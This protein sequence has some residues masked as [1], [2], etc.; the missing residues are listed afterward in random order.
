MTSS[1]RRNGSQVTVK[2][3]L[4]FREGFRADLPRCRDAITA[5]SKVTVRSGRNL[6]AG[7]GRRTP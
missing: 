7:K 1:G 3:D 5:E 2:I 6:S 4:S